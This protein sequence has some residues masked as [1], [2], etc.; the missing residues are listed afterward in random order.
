MSNILVKGRGGLRDLLMAGIAA[1][2]LLSVD[3]LH[4]QSDDGQTM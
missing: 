2:A 3:L 4:S 1:G